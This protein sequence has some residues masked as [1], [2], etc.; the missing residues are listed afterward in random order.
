MFIYFGFFYIYVLF[1]IC[2]FLFWGFFYIYIYYFLFIFVMGGF[3]HICIISYL[4]IFVWGLFLHICI[5]S[6]LFIF[7]LGVFLHICIISYLFIFVFWGF[8]HICIIPYLFL[9][10]GVFYIHV[11]F[12]ICLFIYSFL[13]ALGLCCHPRAFSSCGE[14]SLLSSCVR[15][16]HCGGFSI[17]QSSRHVGSGIVGPGLSCSTACGV[18]VPRPEIELTPPALAGGRLIT[19]PPGKPLELGLGPKLCVSVCVCLTAA[20]SLQSC[21]TLCGPVPGILQARTLERVA[22][23]FSNV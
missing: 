22:I 3:L 15:A 1:L 20:K 14:W 11:L 12:L 9:F 18:L 5:I 19:G 13:A 23:A 4:F 16:S 8:L 10:W 7:V 2:L 6:Y 17:A 21:L